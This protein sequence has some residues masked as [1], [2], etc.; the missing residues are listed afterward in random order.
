MVAFKSL[1]VLLALSVEG[2]AALNPTST[3]STA[4]GTKSVKNV[5]TSRATTVKKITVIKKVV[6]K[7][8]VVV[9]PVAKTSTIRETKIHTSTVIADQATK[10]ATSTIV[11]KCDL[12]YC[13]LPQ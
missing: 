11:C 4:L 8:N 9:I 12:F 7:V 2:I 6:R 1:L 10:T 3:C 5:P 13:L